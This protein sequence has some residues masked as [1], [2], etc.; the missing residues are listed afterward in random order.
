MRK[1]SNRKASDSG[2]KTGGNP[3]AGGFFCPIFCLRV[4]GSRLKTSGATPV[5]VLI[6]VIRRK[7]ADAGRY[8][9]LASV[10]VVIFQRLS[11]PPEMVRAIPARVRW[12]RALRG[13]AAFAGA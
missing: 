4:S 13:F 12:G 7:L 9:R 2:R 10:E 1:R 6:K 3:A 11:S 5:K 8:A